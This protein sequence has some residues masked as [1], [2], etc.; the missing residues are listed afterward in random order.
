MSKQKAIAAW[1]EENR[2][3]S[4]PSC[5]SPRIARILYG[6]PAFDEELEDALSRGTVTLGGC[7]VTGND[8]EWEC[9]ECGQ[10]IRPSG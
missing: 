1:A 3:R 9:I 5:G 8:P 10:T 2:P 4:C 7:L 6:L